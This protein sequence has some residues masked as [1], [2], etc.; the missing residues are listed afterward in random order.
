MPKAKRKVSTE[1]PKVTFRFK[2]EQVSKI[3][4]EMLAV[5]FGGLKY[6]ASKAS[7]W[8]TE[9]V[10]QVKDTLKSNFKT[11]KLNSRFEFT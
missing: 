7:E 10:D 6:D 9:I 5:K 8:T 3:L 11:I 4:K 1:K 2:S